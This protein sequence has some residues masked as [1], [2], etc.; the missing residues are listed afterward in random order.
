[1]FVAAAAYCDDPF[2]I[3]PWLSTPVQRHRALFISVC[4]LTLLDNR[5]AFQHISC[6]YTRTCFVLEL[7]LT[8][9]GRG[10]A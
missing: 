2:K 6:V 7:K 3:V 9:F 5:K 8:P 1:M 10:E 4:H